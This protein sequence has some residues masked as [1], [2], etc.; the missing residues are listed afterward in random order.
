MN[1][2]QAAA[3][4]RC[5]PSICG[6][7]QPTCARQTP[8]SQPFIKSLADSCSSRGAQATLP[9]SGSANLRRTCTLHLSPLC[10][11]SPWQAY[12][13]DHTMAGCHI[14][15]AGGQPGIS[16]HLDRGSACRRGG[17]QVIALSGRPASAA[18]GW[19]TR[20]SNVLRCA[21]AL[22]VVSVP[23]AS[24]GAAWMEG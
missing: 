11:S 5:C 10:P 6:G 17:R 23:H 9:A 1:N 13:A 12:L 24:M 4:S 15:W 20:G 7:W 16:L 21:R 8:N 18:G 22:R 14:S 19:A 3:A 2:L